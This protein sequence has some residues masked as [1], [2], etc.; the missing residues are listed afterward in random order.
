MLPA[1]TSPIAKTPGR[2]ERN[3]SPSLARFDVP[4]LI[5]HC[6]LDRIVPVVAS[7]LRTAKMVKGAP[8]IVPS[9][10]SLVTA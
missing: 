3:L 1:G 10:N 6:D 9:R 8:K 5:I 7:D 2:L 4:T